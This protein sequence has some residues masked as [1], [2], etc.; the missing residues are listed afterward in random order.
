MVYSGLKIN[1][2]LKW[3]DLNT[4]DILISLYDA[5]VAAGTVQKC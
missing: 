3:Y 2:C 1:E 5:T 4:S